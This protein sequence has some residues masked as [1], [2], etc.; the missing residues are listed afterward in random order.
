MSTCQSNTDPL[1]PLQDPEKLA[2]EIRRCAC[3]EAAL[4]TP[5]SI[6]VPLPG[7]PN[8]NSMQNSPNQQGST[9]DPEQQADMSNNNLIQAILVLQQNTAKQLLAAQEAAQ[10]AQA[11]AWADLKAVQA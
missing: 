5:T 3:L 9:N 8:P 2:W 10:V 11:Q 1:I 6:S 4:A 7:I